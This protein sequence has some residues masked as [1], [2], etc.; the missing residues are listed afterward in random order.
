MVW[1]RMESPTLGS[2]IGAYEAVMAG[3]AIPSYKLKFDFLYYECEVK[4][5]F[6]EFLKDLQ[7]MWATM[8]CVRVEL[9]KKKWR[10]R[11]SNIFGWQSISIG[12]YLELMIVLFRKKV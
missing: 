1:W 7:M 12:L 3:H 6:L 5:D 8:R 2:W 11:S 10:V 9:R 4:L